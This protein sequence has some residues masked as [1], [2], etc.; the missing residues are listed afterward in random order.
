M[1]ILIVDDHAIVRK[2]LIQLLKEEFISVDITEASNTSE[3]DANITNKVWDVILLDISL[4]GQNGIDI[5]MQ[6]RASGIKAPVLMLSMHPEEQYALR[7]LKIGANGFLNKNNAP[8]ELVSAINKILSGKIYVNPVLA[9][10]LR[11]SID[12]ELLE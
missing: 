6:L 4:A 5:L 2:G 9:E 7:V 1:N 11:G 3:V 12:N 10:K 8:D